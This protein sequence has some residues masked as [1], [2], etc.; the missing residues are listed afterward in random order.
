MKQALA[1]GKRAP[2][3]TDPLDRR[4]GSRSSENSVEIVTIGEGKI[5]IQIKI[6]EPTMHLNEQ[7]E[8]KIK[9]KNLSFVIKTDRFPC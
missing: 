1:S 8:V 3:L 4:L 6:C 9:M 2:T 5:S 7:N